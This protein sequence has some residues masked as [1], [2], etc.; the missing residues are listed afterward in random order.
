MRKSIKRK[1][2]RKP[3]PHT[4]TPMC[5][6]LFIPRIFGCPMFKINSVRLAWEIERLMRMKI[7]EQIVICNC[8]VA[9]VVD[10]ST[11]YTTNVMYHVYCQISPTTNIS[12]QKKPALYVQ[13]L[14]SFFFIQY[15]IYLYA[16]SIYYFNT[17][18]MPGYGYSDVKLLA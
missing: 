3:T 15:T 14:S 17:R 4:Y 16:N 1:V 13:R 7:Q 5:F 9:V 12:L 8:L 6:Y 18:Q 2:C 11:S 10:I